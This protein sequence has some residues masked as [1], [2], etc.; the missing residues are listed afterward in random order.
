MEK[1][2]LCYFSAT[3]MEIPS[4]SQGVRLF[5]QKG[6]EV[7]VYAR[8][9]SQLFDE[10]QIERFVNKALQSH[11][12]FIA[13]H[14]GR[15]SCPAMDRLLEMLKNG[16]DNNVKLFHIQPV[17]GDEEA[18]TLS[19]ENSHHFG[20]ELWDSL[21]RY[22]VHGGPVNF[23][24]MMIILYNHVFNT[25]FSVE[26][27]EKPPEEGIYHP[28]FPAPVSLE[29]YLKF[30]VD[31]SRPTVGIWFYQSYWLNGNLAY[32]DALIREVENQGANALA[33]FHLRYKDSVRGNKGAD[34]VVE[35]FFMEGD[36]SR[37]DVLISPMMF[38]LT[39]A[40]PEY[41]TLYQKLN[42][43][44]IQAILTWNSYEAWRDSYQGLC[45]MDV[46]YSVA[47]PEFDGAIITVPVGYR[48][49]DEVDPLTGALLCKFEPI[50]E[51][52]KKVVSMALKWARL[53]QKDP[54]DRKVAI[55][56]H[57]YPPRNDRIGCAAG[58]DSFESVVRLLKELK[59]EGYKIDKLYD[60]GDELAHDLLSCVTNDRRWLAPEKIAEK[61]VAKADSGLYKKWY[62]QFPE[63][64]RG[65]LQDHWGKLPGKLMVFEDNVVFPGFINGNVFITIQP[66]RG[67]F[68][69]IDKLYHDPNLS[70]PY[71]YLFFYRWIRDIFGAD[72]VIH[73]GK[74]GS[75][76]WLPGKSVGLSE[77]CY[78][79]MSILDLPNI[80]PYIIN[81]PSEG[82]QAK[83][84]SYC[85][86]IDHLTPVFTNADLYED[87][88][89]VDLLLKEYSDAKNEDPGK[90]DV[91]RPM[92]W[93]AVKKADLDKE[94]QMS[95]EEVFNNFDG[96]LERLHSYLG[97]IA[98]TMI[99]DG[100]HVLGEV[101][102]GKRLVEYLV[103]LTRLPN[104]DVPSLRFSVLDAM[105]FNYEE[106]IENKGRI[107]PEAGG[108]RGWEI[109][110]D[111]HERCIALVERVLKEHGLYDLESI[112]FE[113]INP[114]IK[115]DAVNQ[116]ILEELGVSDRNISR[117]LEYIVKILVL[118]LVKTQDELVSTSSALA[119]RF[120]L[121][122]PSGAP[123]RGQADILPTGRNFYSVD[124]FKIPSPSAWEVGKRLGDAL[125]ERCLKEKGNYPESV[126]I[127]LFGG[128][129][130]RTKGDDLAEILYLL[131]VKPVWQ[132]GS[133]N[134]V[135]LEVIPLDE[136][137]RPRI[138]VVPRIS[139]FFRDAFPNLVELIDEAV[140]MVALLD[141][142]FE[143]NILR[144]HVFDDME[145][146]KKQGMNE[147]DAFREATFR[148]F[149]CPPG[150]YGAG[151]TELI[152]SKR[153]K[154][155]ED[156]ANA[157]IRYSSH[158]YGKGVYGSKKPGTFR[159]VLSRMDVTV[160]NEDSREYD[161]FSCTDY[162][163][164]YGGL[165]VSSK[166][167]R[168]ELPLAFMGDSSDPRRVV[169][170][171]TQEEAKHIFRSRLLNP[172]WLEGMKR[173]GF[174]GAGDIS[175]VIDIVLGWSAT[176]EV[177]DDWM[178]ERLAQK[179]ALDPEMQEWLR[180]VNPY[181]LENILN[182][183]LDAI[184]RGLWKADENMEKQLRDAYLAIEGIIE[185][186]GEGS[187]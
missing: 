183:L 38:S 158:V 112:R 152:E 41:K 23:C 44:V 131:G 66:T 4:L 25:D 22:F 46:S 130:M 124:P 13:L 165:I 159:K 74:H 134:V 52:I 185:E 129:T 40:S 105:G 121:P 58:L 3:A 170:R 155:Q 166:V 157:Y 167:I 99:N 133:G 102:S 8:T 127:I 60:R 119:G 95:E 59:N 72:A 45:P 180:E 67:E 29:D 57:N 1:L 132:K 10:R 89:E 173:H 94:I 107:F 171:T 27:P 115:E 109:I 149:G 96:F 145:A 9:K 42:V 68:E 75:L 51:R 91:L 65:K 37:I 7:S 150:S 177:V 69:N 83:R 154:T 20:T 30:K 153:W 71:Y 82:T 122:G 78:P 6:F 113:D 54:P 73:V 142:P 116:I 88:A 135:G 86:I 114:L 48:S 39:L 162:Y 55:I 163:N 24:N 164:Y 87:L 179:Y 148:I 120:V 147:K 175:K 53:R 97:E 49:E 98:D 2:K 184:N 15:A 76:E 28:D 137:G 16:R 156:L 174:K 106:I 140:G 64:I 128:S 169:I 125:L 187:D 161:M 63:I 92:I 5:K 151:V 32:V 62:E 186:A 18:L 34:Y 11:V 100:L 160:K 104:G 33:V 146:Y 182:K 36:K 101:P 77:L 172:K 31:S 139:G 19:Q 90:L 138:D 103:Q 118:S 12:V 79:D 126:G 123:T 117:A 56:F 168:G 178:Y 136:L 43:P 61:A 111:V 81:D 176:A 14:G 143:S 85:C 80:Y 84:R 17:G 181:A 141:E 144:K 47:Q 110:K 50:E 35:K 21:N 26:P 93:E 108:R 70:P